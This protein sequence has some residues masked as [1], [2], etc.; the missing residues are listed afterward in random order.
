[1]VMLVSGVLL[2]AIVHMIPGPGRT[3][4]QVLVLG[5]GE[6]PYKG[7]FSLALIASLLLIVFGWR[8]T[9][10]Q[11]VYLPP[12]WG[13]IA[14]IALMPVAI[15]LFGAS[16]AKTRVK[17]FIRHPQLSSIV[18]WSGA[19]LLANGDDRSLV[20]FG[21]MGLWA[22]LEILVINRRDRQWIKPPV[23]SMAAE[24]RGIV[25]AAV[26]FAVLVFLHP[27]FAGVAVLQF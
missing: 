12:A 19:H 14:A 25:I 18:V 22:I 3:L 13:G 8:S 5:V 26:V 20:L 4:R 11:P 7:V 24:I 17:R 10:P 2:W 27:K 1:M 23:P 21:G 9:P 6:K 16:H 15:F